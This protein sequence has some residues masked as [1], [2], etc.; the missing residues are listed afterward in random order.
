[1]SNRSTFAN[2][3]AFLMKTTQDMQTRY[4]TAYEKRNELRR[5]RD[6]V[7]ARPAQL[8]DMKAMVAAFV[9]GQ[10]AQ[11]VAKLE[12][13]LAP[14]ARNPEKMR[15]E[16]ERKHLLTIVG[17]PGAEFINA[18]DADGALCALFGEQLVVA[19]NSALDDCKFPEAGLSLV[20]RDRQLRELDI[21]IAELDAEL[22]ELSIIADEAGI[23]ITGNH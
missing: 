10:R 15:V 9:R 16:A 11:Y 21:E 17:V 7:R 12:A 22:E 6:A 20:E 1:M 8:S 2:L 23:V 4:L 5:K 13:N 19:M 14:F 18:K 3:K